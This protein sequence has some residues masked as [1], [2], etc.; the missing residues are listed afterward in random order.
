MILVPL[1][2]LKF[3]DE[4]AATLQEFKSAALVWFSD[5]KFLCEPAAEVVGTSNPPH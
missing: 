4:L 5:L 3:L 2:D 1:F